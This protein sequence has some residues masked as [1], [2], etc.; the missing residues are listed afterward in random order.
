MSPQTGAAHLTAALR[1]ALATDPQL[2]LIGADVRRGGPF[3][4]TAGLA[5]RS[6][7]LIELPGSDRAALGVAAGLAIGGLRPVLLLDGAGRLAALGA[8]LRSLAALHHHAP[9]PLVIVAP[10]GT[11]AGALDIP[12]GA[13]ALGHGW[14]IHCATTPAAVGA[15]LTRALAAGGPA[16]V[17][18]QRTA[19]T[20]RGDDARTGPWIR[21]G[22]HATVVAWGSAVADA[23][24]AAALLGAEGIEVG[25]FALSTLA[26]LDRDG[27]AQAVR[28]SGR[29]VIA[30]PDDPSAAAVIR[31]VAAD[32]AFLY[33]ESP[34]AQA[35]GAAQIAAAVRRSVH[36]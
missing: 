11:E 22:G 15:A 10:Y 14:S 1:A 30:H 32:A 5:D 35:A 3:G 23:E 25:V 9:L 6:Q 24:G 28:T 16:V 7:A 20:E 26:P 8:A 18:A 31:G 13:D 33:L 19:L 34:P 17:L 4:V 27:L 2:R 29:L 36:Y 21:E 12:L